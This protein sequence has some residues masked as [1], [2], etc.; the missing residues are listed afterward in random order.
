MNSNGAIL[1][2]E[3]T[4][5]QC[6]RRP[7]RRHDTTTIERISKRAVQPLL[8]FHEEDTTSSNLLERVPTSSSS[9]SM[10]D[11][12]ISDSECHPHWKPTA[13]Q[14]KRRRS[15]SSRRRRRRMGREDSSAESKRTPSN[16]ATKVSKGSRRVVRDLVNVSF[17]EPYNQIRESLSEASNAFREIRSELRNDP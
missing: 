11:S 8:L 5:I 3:Q 14:E 12:S 6:R 10:S 15:S 1:K 17:V 2:K 13:I 4:S 9:S 16:W 7:R